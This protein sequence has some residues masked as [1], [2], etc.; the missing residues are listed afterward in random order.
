MQSD[1]PKRHLTENDV[2]LSITDR[3]YFFALQ[4]RCFLNRSLKETQQSHKRNKTYFQ[5]S[6]CNTCLAYCT[7]RFI[8][9]SVENR[10]L[11]NEV[12]FKVY[13]G[14]AQVFHVQFG[15]L[16]Q[17]LTR[18]I[19]HIRLLRRIWSGFFFSPMLLMM[20]QERLDLRRSSFLVF[21]GTSQRHL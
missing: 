17:A 1:I 10:T 14:L 12:F 2:N 3:Q 6:F 8:F 18:T 16:V 20:T 13:E 7:K 11:T 5:H 19:L 4:W 15:I 21:I 9:Q